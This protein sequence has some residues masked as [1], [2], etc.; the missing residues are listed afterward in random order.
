MIVIVI[1]TCAQE[2]VLVYQKNL[3]APHRKE[4]KKWDQY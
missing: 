1:K 4:E 2:V 3:C